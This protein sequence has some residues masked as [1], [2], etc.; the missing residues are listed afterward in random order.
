MCA[1]GVC[2]V[3]TWALGGHLPVWPN[4]MC[5][6]CVCGVCAVYSWALGGRLPVWP[7]ATRGT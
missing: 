7:N 1:Y 5:H 4:A 6:V 3:Y 2:A